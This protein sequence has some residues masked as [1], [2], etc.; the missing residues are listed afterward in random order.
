MKRKFKHLTLAD[1]IRIEALKNAGHNA[2][3]IARIIGVHHATIYRELKRGEYM[4]RDYEYRDIIKYSPELAH[5]KY[6]ENLRSKGKMLK[7]GNDIAYANYIEN[8]IAGGY[9]PAALLGELK[10]KK[11]ENR[12]KTKICFKTLY[13]YIDMGI[14]LNI[15]NKD[16]HIKKNKKR[17]SRKIRKVQKR[18]A[19]GTSIEKR[20]SEINER[21]DFGHWEMDSVIGKSKNKG[22]PALLVLTERKSRYEIIRKLK[23]HTANE[24]VKQIDKLEKEYGKQFKHIFK[25][26]TVD[27]GSEFAYSEKIEQSKRNKGKRTKLYY[28]HPYSSYERGSNENANRLIRRYVPKSTEIIQTDKEIQQIED[29][30]NN[31]PRRIHNYHT[32]KEI[33]ESELKKAI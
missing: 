30:I 7:I 33:F 13:K 25:S 16:L 2:C 17:G 28:C 14:F 26:I 23:S 27:N 1:R 9:S 5:D 20:P 8:K 4:T 24:V 12:F 10:A 29:F 15:T 21:K 32:A 31:Y 3:D 6:R 18:P 22:K 11:E 19:A